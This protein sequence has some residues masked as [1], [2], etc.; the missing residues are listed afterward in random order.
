MH[1][2]DFYI[3][4]FFCFLIIFEEKFLKSKFQGIYLQPLPWMAAIQLR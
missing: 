4:I 1:I 2:D 3:W